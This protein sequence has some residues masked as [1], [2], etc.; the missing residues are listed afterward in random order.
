M[1]EVKQ[2]HLARAVDILRAGPMTAAQFAAKMW[3]DRKNADG[4]ERSHSQLSH[5]GHAFLRRIGALGYA[6]H[7]A[8]LWMIHQFSG[9]GSADHSANG[10]ADPSANGLTNGLGSG[11]SNH[12]P[13]H[14][15][16]STNG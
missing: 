5:A 12:P 6:D 15:P 9:S 2:A 13:P 4:G 1:Y 8:D 11:H 3:P 16:H 14:R 10:F 7:V